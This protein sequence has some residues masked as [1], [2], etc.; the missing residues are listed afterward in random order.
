M[1]A[2]AAIGSAIGAASAPW[3]LLAQAA[4]FSAVTTPARKSDPSAATAADSPQGGADARNAPDSEGANG[5]DGGA[6]ASNSPASRKAESDTRGTEPRTSPSTLPP[7]RTRTTVLELTLAWQ[8][9]SLATEN[10]QGK[11][12][13]YSLVGYSA[14]GAFCPTGVACILAGTASN[15]NAKSGSRLL[16]GVSLGGQAFLLGRADPPPQGDKETSGAGTRPPRLQS[17]WRFALTGA[18]CQ[19][20]YD[21]TSLYAE[22]DAQIFIGARPDFEGSFWCAQ[23][24]ATIDYLFRSGHRV[25]LGIGFFRSLKSDMAVLKVQGMSVELRYQILRF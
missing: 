11:A 19:K 16:T 1:S 20:D 7:S 10:S 6:A 18:F 13:A 12:S 15:L 4:P 24:N 22:G 2:F 14:E 21:F 8:T 3:I 17:I 9:Q 25:G 5:N 23:G